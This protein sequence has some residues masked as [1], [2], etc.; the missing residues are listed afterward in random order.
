MNKNSNIL[1]VN[2]IFFCKQSAQEIILQIAY[3]F[4]SKINQKHRK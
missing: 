4:V 3:I 2:T 1:H